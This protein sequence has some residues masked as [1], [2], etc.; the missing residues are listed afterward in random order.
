MRRIINK[1]SEKGYA[2]EAIICS[3]DAK[4]LDGVFFPAMGI[5]FVDGT[6]PHAMEPK[7]P[8]AVECYLPL[9]QF[10][11]DAALSRERG[12]VIGL[13]TA[14]REDYAHLTRVLSAVKSL[15]DEQYG[16][17]FSLTAQET[18]R[19]RARGIIRR[20]IKKGTG[21]KLHKRFLNALSAEGE[22]VLWES[23]QGMAEQV[24]E[25]QDSYHQAHTLLAP[26]LAAALEAGQEVYACYDTCAP[27]SRLKHLILPD[28]R[29]AFV[30]ATVKEPY[31]NEPYRRIRFDACIPADII[32]QN[33]L[34]L[35]FL[36]KTEAALKQDAC[37]ILAGIADKHDA[38]E[39]VYNPHVDFAGVRALADAYAEK[40]LTD[41]APK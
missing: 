41:W 27:E 19:R 21:A 12:T 40:I 22:K 10:A 34:R 31:P 23:V 30:S 29:L 4:S 14:L 36:R 20:E 25:L 35:R 33:R 37:E 24:Y 8:L 5:A 39:A 17:I 11:D 26:V 38:L 15:Q 9:T 32:R 13:Q 18:I 7:Y 2:Y 6:A 1:I 28:L 3:G 16:M